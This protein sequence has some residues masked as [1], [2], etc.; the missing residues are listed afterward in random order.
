MTLL[1]EARRAR[2]WSQTQLVHALARQAAVEGLAVPGTE[3]LRIMISRWENGRAQPD[4]TYR[5]YLCAAY[6]ADPSTLGLGIPG[7]RLNEPGVPTAVPRQVSEQLLA[8]LDRSF[9]EYVCADNALGAAHVL[10]LVAQQARTLDG[11][12]AS[13]RGRDRVEVLSRSSRYAEMCGWL[14]QDLGELVEAQRWSDRALEYAEELGDAQQLSYVLMR[15]SNI[16]SDRQRPASALGLAQAALRPGVAL[17]PRLRAVALRQ[18]AAAAA[19]AGDAQMCARALAEAEDAVSN[20]DPADPHAKYVSAAY[21]ASEASQCWLTLGNPRRAELGL[22]DALATWPAGHHRD[23]AIGLCRL[24]AAELAQRN[25]EEAAATALQAAHAARQV[26]SPRL[27]ARLYALRQGLQ[28]WR[29]VAS[30]AAVTDSMAAVVAT[31]RP[32]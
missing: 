21:I 28:R 7:P 17:S 30:V 5:G 19:Q 31:G 23:Q 15:K 25:V 13:T 10:P 2:G 3:S 4:A 6:D 14:C 16:A 11:L 8:H 24:A 27:H 9:T 22:R 29:S 12:A 32:A 1:R 20:A 18:E 26:A